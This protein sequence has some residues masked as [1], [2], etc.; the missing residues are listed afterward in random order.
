MHCR[1]FLGKNLK[2]YLITWQL[3]TFPAVSYILYIIWGNLKPKISRA[4]G[5]GFQ[6][7][8][9]YIA[10][11]PTMRFADVTST[12]HASCKQEQSKFLITR[13]VIIIIHSGCV[14][15]D[16]GIQHAMR[17]RHIVIC[18]LPRCTKFFLLI[19][20]MAGFSK[21][22]NWILKVCFDFLYRYFLKYF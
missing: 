13:Q 7:V 4:S 20:Q 12:A 3:R 5:Y 11:V 18:G 22:K 14:S 17:M 1:Q 21:K 15:V 10:E 2:R 16:L 8:T 19:S 9:L 6:L